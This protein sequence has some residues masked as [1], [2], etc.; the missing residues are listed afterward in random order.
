MRRLCL[1]VASL[2]FGLSS[3]HAQRSSEQDFSFIYIA[4]DENT[5]VQYLIERLQMAYSD[6][7]NY[8]DEI[9]VV[10]YLPNGDAPLCVEVNTKSDNRA[11]FD[12]IVDELQT[13]RSHNIEPKTDRQRV[14][15]IFNA[16]DIIDDGGNPLYKSV[17]LTY[18]VNSTFWSLQNNEYV[19]ASLFFVMDMEP[20]IQSGYL[21]VNVLYSGEYDLLPYDKELPFGSKRLWPSSVPFMPMPY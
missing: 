14:Q 17:T 9:A 12:K 5:P 21:K 18:Y 20:M 15:D 3:V 1:L 4:H 13:K 6:A 2:L 16:N 19:I 8:P 10:F 11:D 7:I